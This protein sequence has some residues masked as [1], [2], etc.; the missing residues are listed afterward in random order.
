[1]TPYKYDCLDYT[2]VEVDEKPLK[3]AKVHSRLGGYERSIYDCKFDLDKS[4]RP[5]SLKYQDLAV[6]IYHYPERKPITNSTV[7]TKRCGE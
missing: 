5:S 7:L 3:D 2:V 6:T 4:T 1:V